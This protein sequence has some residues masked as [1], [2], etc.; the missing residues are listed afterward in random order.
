MDIFQSKSSLNPDNI[1][2]PLKGQETVRKTIDKKVEAPPGGGQKQD[3]PILTFP[4]IMSG[5]AGQFA[6]LYS[7]YLEPPAH[8]FYIA[9][10]ACLG[11]LKN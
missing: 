2:S 3:S 6:H 4:G 8:F 1:P 11:A 5:A 7:S 10:L 9:F